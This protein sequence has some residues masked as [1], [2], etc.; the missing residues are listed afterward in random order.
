MVEGSFTNE[1][2]VGSN[3]AAV[4]LT[5]HVIFILFRWKELIGHKLNALY[6]KQTQSPGGVSQK[7][8]IDLL[9][10]VKFTGKYLC[11]RLF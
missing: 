10:F 5:S 6:I 2:A 7:S 11:C 3:P 4:A 8:Y 9:N 1:E